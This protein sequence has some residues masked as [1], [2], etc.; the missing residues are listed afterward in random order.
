[1]GGDERGEADAAWLSSVEE[2]RRG[3][4]VQLGVS[5]CGPTA[6]LNILEAC[7]YSPLPSAAKVLEAA[8]ARLRDHSTPS[9]VSYLTSRA[10]AGTTHDDLIRGAG[11]LTD[12]R[13]SG[14]FF[15]VDQFASPEALSG[16][17][18][19]WVSLGAAPLVTLN[20]FLEG[21]DAYHHQTVFGVEPGG[22]WTSN[23][24][25]KY[26]P[27]HLLSLL[28]AGRHMVIPRSHVLARLQAACATGTITDLLEETELLDATPPWSDLA[29][30]MQVRRI[31]TG[32]ADTSESGA[33]MLPLN[34]GGAAEKPS[35][36]R[37]L[38]IPWG[39]LPGITVFALHGTPAMSELRAASERS[40]KAHV[41]LPLYPVPSSSASQGAAA[42]VVPVA[43]RDTRGGG[44]SVDG[45]PRGDASGE[46]SCSVSPSSAA[47]AGGREPTS[48]LGPRRQHQQ[49]Q[50]QWMSDEASGSA[51]L[52]Q[53]LAS[54][55]REM[56]ELAAEYEV[57]AAA[58]LRAA[59]LEAE[60]LEARR[61]LERERQAA[62]RSRVELLA[63]IERL[64]RALDTRRPTT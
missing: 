47:A 53:E 13:V 63:E 16:W 20:L 22:I 27:A 57:Q 23:P 62:G 26:S 40:P 54:V 14:V 17:L 24:V 31:L 9:L 55:A 59:G 4:A 39:G 5:A 34:G 36:F 35:V 29:V 38:V 58:A 41:R 3:S 46:P 49:Q 30:G 11:R 42:R 12:G 51:A 21:Q 52:R 61:E 6:L 48:P 44:G 56:A 45:T 2:M 28:T 19:R 10:K 43:L 33:R 60:L 7:R 50:Q 32:V 18:R 25:M 37:D 1:M 8:P 15:A 64:H